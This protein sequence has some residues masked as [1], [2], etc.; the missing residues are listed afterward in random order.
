MKTRNIV[1]AQHQMSKD[2]DIVIT[3][4]QGKV[5]LSVVVMRLRI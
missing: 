3:G 4:V 5:I 1:T 2:G